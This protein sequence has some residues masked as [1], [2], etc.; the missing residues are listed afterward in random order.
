MKEYFINKKDFFLKGWYIDKKICDDLIKYFNK[1]KNAH[2]QGITSDRL[3]NNYK[4][5]KNSTELVLSMDDENLKKY[6]FSLANCLT[7]YKKIYP[8]VD[9][10][11]KWSLTE[12]VNI[13][14]YKPKEGFLEWH[15]ERC[16]LKTSTRLLVFMT[17]LNDIEEGGE[18]E[19][20]F[21][22]LKIKP[23]KGLTVIWPA[24]WL[25]LHRGCAAKKET[26][27]IITG[28]FSFIE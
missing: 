25:Y 4:Q 19:W 20:F 15:A 12:K 10:I 22:K 17:Y 21:Q 16:G 13:Q 26:K 28:W 8:E 3:D 6:S 11:G 23:E 14:K 9:K 1:N 2:V 27:Y 24:E 5:A 7:E 18:T